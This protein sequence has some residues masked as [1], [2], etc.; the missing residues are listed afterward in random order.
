MDQRKNWL[1]R[2]KTQVFP[3]NLNRDD[4]KLLMLQNIA[5]EARTVT[6]GCLDLFASH[7]PPWFMTEKLPRPWRRVIA[8]WILKKFTPHT[9]IVCQNCKSEPLTQAHIVSCTR[10][11]CHYPVEAQVVKRYLPEWLLSQG[12]VSLELIA[13]ELVR[14]I[15]LCYPKIQFTAAKEGFEKFGSAA[16][17]AAPIFLSEH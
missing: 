7:K 4:V 2:L 1:E 5:E 3:A 8:V 15:E 9:E 17:A 6:S 14:C 11:F 12:T 16:K 13:F 10:M